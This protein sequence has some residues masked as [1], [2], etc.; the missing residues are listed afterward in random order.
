MRKGDP[1]SEPAKRYVSEVRDE[2]ARRTRRAIV[3]AARELFLAQG[4]AATTIDAIAEAA[5]VSRR[6]V[7]NSAGGK[8]ALLKLALDWAIVGD[9]EPVAMADRPAVAV[10]QAE[11]DPQQ[12]LRLWARTITDAAARIAPIA[13]VLYAAADGDPDAA[14]LLAESARGRMFGARAFVAHLASLDA[15]AAGVSEQQAADLCW[16]LMDAH[17]YRLLVGERGWTAEELERW[18]SASLA[19]TLLRP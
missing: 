7:F 12:A 3:T 9:D 8:V 13:A 16:A 15:L 2:Q 19:A 18:L 10:I 14:D 17:L 11:R 5:H 6:T 1:V 4:Y